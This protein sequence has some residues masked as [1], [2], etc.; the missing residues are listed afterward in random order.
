MKRFYQGILFLTLHIFVLLGS[1]VSMTEKAGRVLDGSAFADKK[2]AV[3]KTP[4]KET[5]EAELR[6][7]Q[8]KDGLRSI[9]II[10]HQFPSIKFRCSFPNES[11]EIF[12]TSLDYLAGSYNGWNE[13][14]LDLFGS[15]ILTFAGDK[16]IL[17]VPGK[18][19]KLEIS[20]GRLRRYDMRITGTEA[21]ARLRDRHERIKALAEW[22]K[23]TEGAP[24]GLEEK[25]F[26]KHWKPLLF[27]EMVSKKKR[28][29]AW[30]K[31]DDQWVRAEDIRWNKSYTE[32]FFPEMLYEIRNSG[33]MLR[34]WEEALP[35]IYIEYEWERILEML[36][37]EII[38]QKK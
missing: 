26:E 23:Q 3:Y 34:D 24:L 21:L 7:V 12:F 13:Y 1:C 29:A 6:E 5:P 25:A 28:P 30:M 11:G 14:S 9:I 8:N 16:A 32:R 35:W 36:S 18:I 2:I 37:R 33:T 17:E 20:S 15:G 31:E 27:P 4:K 10:L 19:E 22:M 38:L